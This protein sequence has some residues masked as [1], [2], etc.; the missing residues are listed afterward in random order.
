MPEI[1]TDI[2]VPESLRRR[3]QNFME[4]RHA[5][6][7]VDD[8]AEDLSPQARSG[9]QRRRENAQARLTTLA[10]PPMAAFY[11]GRPVRLRCYYN[12]IEVHPF[13]PTMDQTF[14]AARLWPFSMFGNLNPIIVFRLYQIHGLQ[15][16]IS[17]F[18]GKFTFRY[19]R[20]EHRLRMGLR[21]AQAFNDYLRANTF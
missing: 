17:Y 20:Q 9:M 4:G 16:Q 2:H 11:D 5:C 14:N 19:D 1:N 8:A 10:I 12:R 7:A 13:A 18:G 21:S 3:G 15:Q 6:N